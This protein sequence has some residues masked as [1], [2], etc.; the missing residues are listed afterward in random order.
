MCGSPA[1]AAGPREAAAELPGGDPPGGA[2][3]R[4]V[5]AREHRPFRDESI[6]LQP[7]FRR[8]P[9]HVGILHVGF[10][11]NLINMLLSNTN[12]NDLSAKMSTFIKYK[13]YLNCMA[14]NLFY[15]RR[16]GQLR[17]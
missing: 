2:D 6:F 13:V 7:I 17:V 11:F 4:A 3:P 5:Q 1:A 12:I 9:R 16:L 8:F 10:C 15:L 14:F